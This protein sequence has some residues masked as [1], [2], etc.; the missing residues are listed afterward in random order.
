MLCAC[1]AG[2]VPPARTTPLAGDR[3]A[4]RVDDDVEDE[5]VLENVHRAASKVCPY[6][7]V[8]ETHEDAEAKSAVVRCDVTKGSGPPGTR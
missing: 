7:Y 3:Y 4:I 5:D 2:V 1:G 6:G 8:V